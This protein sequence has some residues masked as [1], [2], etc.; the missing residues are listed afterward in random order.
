MTDV[1]LQRECTLIGFE[2]T[3]CLM[4]A[5]FRPDAGRRIHLQM[6]VSLDRTLQ[7]FEAS[8]AARNDLYRLAL[9]LEPDASAT[10]VPRE[11]FAYH[12]QHWSILDYTWE[13]M[14]AYLKLSNP[15]SEPVVAEQPVAQ[16][17]APGT[18]RHEAIRLVARATD[19]L[20]ARKKVGIV[21]QAQTSPKAEMQSKSRKISQYFQV[22]SAQLAKAGGKTY[23]EIYPDSKGQASKKTDPLARRTLPSSATGPTTVY[24]VWR[25]SPKAASTLAGLQGPGSNALMPVGNHLTE[26]YERLFEAIWNGETDIVRRMCLPQSDGNPPPY[27][28]LLQITAVAT[29]KAGGP[30]GSWN[31][32]SPSI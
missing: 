5:P 8:I 13:Q 14:E 24:S 11:V 22:A 16:T 21:S 29:Y 6:A 18:W 23:D 4:T 1:L 32:I 10:L 19:I 2:R 3:P 15:T 28:D 30:I 12:F 27:K 26:P 20:M 9:A 17:A 7:P 31:F 25:D